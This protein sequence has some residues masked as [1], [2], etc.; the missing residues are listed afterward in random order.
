[1]LI[2]EQEAVMSVKDRD[3]DKL[4]YHVGISFGDN[5]DVI[6]GLVQSSFDDMPE[7]DE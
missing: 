4:D 6:P 3:R 2:D 7:E 1:M 5:R